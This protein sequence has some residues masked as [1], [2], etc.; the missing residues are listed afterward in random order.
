MNTRQRGTTMLRKIATGLAV[1][2]GLL[3]LSAAPADAR[4]VI[5]P[6]DYQGPI[7]SSHFAGRH[8]VG[9]VLVTNRDGDVY[10]I[11]GEYVCGDGY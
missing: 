3:V 6:P 1:I 8:A 5:D 2:L 7:S 10:Y 4:P 9:C 11:P